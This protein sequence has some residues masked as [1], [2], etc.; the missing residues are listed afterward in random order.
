M[1]YKFFQ[2]IIIIIS[3]DYISLMIKENYPPM[4]L[5]YSNQDLSLFNFNNKKIVLEDV[6]N[7]GSRRTNEIVMYSSDNYS[8][9]NE[10]GYEAQ[11]KENFEVVSLNTNVKM[12]ENG[13]IISGHLEGA[14]KIK[15]NIKIGDYVI[16]IRE[17]NKVYIFDSKEEYKYVYYIFKINNYLKILNK[18]MIQD[19]LYREIYNKLYYINMI[20]KEALE[21]DKSKIINIYWIINDYTINI[22]LK[23]K[24]LTYLT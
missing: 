24:T 10:W 19:K 20:Y 3:L 1:E 13:Y 16:Y 4:N 15:E 6:K 14:R 17:T 7:G 2:L 9:T 11:I 12:I 18:K 22:L 23:E 5:I 21:K 8:P